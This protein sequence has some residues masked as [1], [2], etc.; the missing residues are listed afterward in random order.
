VWHRAVTPEGD[1]DDLAIRQAR[2]GVTLLQGGKAEA[3][4]GLL[5]EQPDPRLRAYLI[6]GLAALGADPAPLLARLEAEPDSGA[7]QGLLFS[8]GQYRDDQLPAAVRHG[9]A[10][11][12][13]ARYR[14]DPD[15][16]VHS[17]IAWLL[18]RWKQEDP[19][20]AIDRQLAT[21][22]PVSQRRWYVNKHGHTLAVL[23]LPA[24]GDALEMLLDQPDHALGPAERAAWPRRR[25]SHS[26]AI[27]TRE[28]TWQ[29]FRH[30]HETYPRFLRPLPSY[31]A[32]ENDSPVGNLTWFEAAA[33]CRWLSE[34]EG[35]AEEQ[36]CYPPVGEIRPGMTLP[37]DYL[38][39]TGY[40]VPTEA[41]WECACRAG[42]VT[43]RYYG[44]AEFLLGRYGWYHDNSRD[45][46]QPVA[47]MLP[48]PLGLF[49]T[50][51][52]VWEWCQDRFV[53]H[54]GAALQGTQEDSEGLDLIVGSEMRLLRGG[55]FH[56]S[57]DQLRSSYRHKDPA[58]SPHNSIGIRV[59][60]TL[61]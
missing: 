15:P 52:N 55:G 23:R 26:F 10:Q 24:M 50:Y 30:F 32:P 20:D 56:V 61:P 6:H 5:R 60:R 2:A 13:L 18:R 29:Q 48:N 40:R 41:E 19:L 58:S 1:R 57:A 14:T 8:L 59:A 43:S 35:I 49:D 12:L 9:L 54:R 28:T 44:H 17:A 22:P 21:A 33:Y 51:G 38:H 3:V 39:R 31:Y 7:R 27:A 42:T 25:V 46:S 47:E 36:M 45:H 37:A 11:R 53:T 4:W 16:G 34:Q